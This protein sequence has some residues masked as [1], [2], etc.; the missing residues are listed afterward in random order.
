MGRS[1]AFAAVGMGEEEPLEECKIALL[2]TPYN[3]W[4]LQNDR[5]HLSVLLVG[6]CT[7][8]KNLLD[9]RG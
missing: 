2:P 1:A 3:R 4:H 7:V 8:F 5:Q 9:D 6:L